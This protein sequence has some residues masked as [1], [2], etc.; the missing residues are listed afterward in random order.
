M[1]R[2]TPHW[3]LDILCVFFIRIARVQ[4]LA[5]DPSVSGLGIRA[6]PF[7]P[8]IY[9]ETQDDLRDT[10]HESSLHFRHP[11]ELLQIHTVPRP[12]WLPG[13]HADAV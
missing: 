13:S 6:L 11:S 10:I 4:V 3:G 1:S 2:Y 5:Q 12:L 8:G 9:L 7:S